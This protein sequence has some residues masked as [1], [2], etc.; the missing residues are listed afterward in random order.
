MIVAE[1]NICTALHVTSMMFQQRRR[2]VHPPR[3][4]QRQLAERRR[5]QQL[6]QHPQPPQWLRR[7]QWLRPL[8]PLHKPQQRPRAPHRWLRRPQL[9]Q[10]R[11]RQQQL[12]LPQR[13]VSQRWPPPPLPPPP[14]ASHVRLPFDHDASLSSLGHRSPSSQAELRLEWL[15]R[16]DSCNSS[17]VHLWSEGKP[18]NPFSHSSSGD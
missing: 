3:P 12:Q 11:P 14:L 18:T 6:S 4:L 16:N 1:S 7:L 5:R 10:A 17:P 8:R 2:L 9:H 15:Q 13:P